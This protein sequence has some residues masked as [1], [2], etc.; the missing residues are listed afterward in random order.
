MAHRHRMA[1]S[2][3]NGGK[4]SG[5]RGISMVYAVATMGVMFGFGSL[6][7]DWGRVQLAKTQARNAADAASRYAAAAL[8]TNPSGV[9][10]AAVS[11]ASQN[12][13]DGTPLVLQ[14]SDI[15]IGVWNTS[16]KTFT[17]TSVNPNAVRV[18]AHRTAA[19]GTAI[20]LVF[21]QAIGK[22][23]CDV[24]V[25]S[26]S[27][28]VPAVDV[29]QDVQA[30]S[31]PFLSGMPAGTQ[32]SGI[33]PHHNPDYAGTSNN[34]MASPSVVNMTLTDGA[35]LTF[36]SI[37]GTARHDPGL[38]YYQPDGDTGDIGHN[39]LTAYD[40]GS[41]GSTYYNE[42]GIADANIPINALVGIFLDDRQ[43]DST[44]APENLDFSTSSS[45]E[46][47]KLNPK[48]K[49]IF[50]IGDGLKSDGTVQQFIA[51]HGA[52]RLL[53]AT[54]DYYEW[55]NNAGDREVVIKRPMKIITVK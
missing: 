50:F 12:K 51:P 45:R 46:F 35:A 44:P 4:K 24:N 28:V 25:E 6:C 10:T 9:L 37:S 54:W 49:Q 15:Q 47:S 32:A 2:T 23:T 39:N 48:L 52:T 31:N 36:D 43:P 26:I 22:K 34:P 42:H 27:M 13:V 8:A 16:T 41:R 11:A 29:D 20:P 3:S 30:T 53:L 7:V 33:N 38:S 21:A 1:K 40:A 14:N 55:S 19:R 5:K 17:Q 18:V